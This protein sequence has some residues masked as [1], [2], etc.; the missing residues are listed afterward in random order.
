MKISKMLFLFIFLFL[1]GFVSSTTKDNY[2]NCDLY[3]ICIDEKGNDA[4]LESL[5]VSGDFM[6]R[7]GSNEIGNLFL[8]EIDGTGNYIL[9]K[10]S[11]IPLI[12]KVFGTTGIGVGGD[13]IDPLFV[14]DGVG[15][16]ELGVGETGDVTNLKVN[17]IYASNIC[18]LNGTNC[19]STD[20]SS[21]NQSYADTLY[22]PLE[23]QRVSTSDDVEFLNITTENITVSN[24]ILA[25]DGIQRGNGT[26]GTAIHLDLTDA[27]G[28]YIP[29]DFN[30]NLV[31]LTLSRMNNAIGMALL[32]RSTLSPSIYFGDENSYQSGILRYNNPSD[33]ME[34]YA[35]SNKIFSV[36]YLSDFILGRGN[37]ASN[38]DL[39]FDTSGNDGG[40]HWENVNNRFLFDDDVF[41]S[42]DL[43]VSGNISVNGQI[44]LT[45]NYSVGSC[46]MNY[47]GG[48]LTS[49][50]CTA[51]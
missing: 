33:A 7:N 10:A 22:Q 19:Q 51:L 38:V 50:N 39:T 1:I 44:G 29:S 6:F 47:M 21:W 18:Y 49:T 45:A 27:G 11:R 48:I 17:E 43:N 9:P 16:L 24:T 12:T 40:F 37:L 2:K 13:S 15:G 30:A 36:N 23:N 42:G 28:Y 25:G 8:W 4:T 20:N 35:R 26:I 32:G 3:G 14:S 34:I 46:W 5:N 31:A 41:I